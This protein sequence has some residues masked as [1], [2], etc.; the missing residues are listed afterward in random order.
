M[1]VYKV[2]ER[3]DA[4]NVKKF[5][6]DLDAFIDSNDSEYRLDFEANKYL[7]SAG[8]RA[9]LS[10][11]KKLQKRGADMTLINVHD[12]VREIFEITGYSRFLAL[13]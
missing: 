10:T 2:G 7:S 5:Q 6:E 4:K 12:A 11:K 3:V 9:I 1:G 13:K 8:L